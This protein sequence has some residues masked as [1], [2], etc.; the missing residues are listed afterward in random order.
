MYKRGA[1]ASS[2]RTSP[3]NSQVLC[4]SFQALHHSQAT[5]C[6]PA[7]WTQVRLVCLQGHSLGL[8][9]LFLSLHGMTMPAVPGFSPKL[10]LVVFC[11]GPTLLVTAAACTYQRMAC[12]FSLA[13]PFSYAYT[14]L[15][16]WSKEVWRMGKW[17]SEI[18]PTQ[19]KR[20]LPDQ[21]TS[22]SLPLDPGLGAFLSAPG[23]CKRRATLRFRCLREQCWPHPGR[24]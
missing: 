3:S 6:P 20:L 7:V 2:S 21:A 17:S 14:S 5:G 19:T 24:S 13:V 22:A 12:T 18:F 8:A 15:W 23:H 9:G 1:R 10:F 16:I 4:H 11:R